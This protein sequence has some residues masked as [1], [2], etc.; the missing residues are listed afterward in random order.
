MGNSKRDTIHACNGLPAG[1]LV[2]GRVGMFAG[3]LFGFAFGIGGLAAGPGVVVDIRASTS[4]FRF[5]PHAAA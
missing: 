5:A 4:P 3:I 2:T 1:R